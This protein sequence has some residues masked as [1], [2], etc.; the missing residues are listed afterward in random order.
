MEGRG[1][2]GEEEEED[3]VP[4]EETLVLAFLGGLY[5]DQGL[6]AVVDFVQKYM[7]KHAL[8]F[9]LERDA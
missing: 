1:E 4:V 3:P 7:Q 6:P 9:L 5:Y 8:A 2:S